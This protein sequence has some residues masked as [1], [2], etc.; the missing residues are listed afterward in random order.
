M[1]TN[2]NKLAT[3]LGALLLVLSVSAGCD[4]P[5]DPRTWAKQLDSLRTQKEALDNL[6]RME[7]EKARLALPELT[8]LFESS[9][10]P[11]HLRAIARLKDPSTVDL[12]IKELDFTS[13]DFENATIAVGFLGDM[14]V[15]SAVAAL[16]KAVGRTLP[17][18]SR[19][20]TVRLA[21]IR[22]LATIG[23]PAATEPLIR[24]LTG[25]ADE[26]D[27]L[28][29]KKAAL[30][31]AEL[32][33]ASAIPGLLQGLFMTGRGANVFQEC[34][35][36]LVRIG[37]PAIDPLIAL[38]QRKNAEVEAMAKKQEFSDNAIIPYKAAYVLGDLRAKKAV[39][40]LLEQLKQPQKGGELS[41]VLIALGQIGV[42]EGVD[43]LI[44]TL[45]NDKIE[46]GVRAAASNGLSMSGDKR[47]VP[48]LLEIAK[49]GYVVVGGQKAS[50]LRASAAVDLAR[51]A[52]KDYYAA[53]NAI[54]ESEKDAEGIFAEVL[55]RMELA[56]T[57]DKDI[58]CYAKNLDDE[59]PARAEKAAFA[60]GFSGDPKKGIPLLLGALKP[61]ASL[62][63]ERFLVHQAI[64]YALGQ[65]ADK[66]CTECVEKLNG[67]IEKD[68]K[69]ALRIPGAG[70]LLGETRV[71]LA[72]IAAR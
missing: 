19:A 28:L 11:E 67:Q 29:N 40:A 44:A 31:L 70:D 50:D 72:R 3:L 24:A 38:L 16:G 34:R 65:L 7:P 26:Q 13:D 14:K 63:H 27:F 25:S 37:E 54:A 6:A 64:L 47:A 23:D 4:D 18:K 8:K 68:E 51:I 2:Q 69:S 41:S 57:C 35:L 32:A 5:N 53:F 33:D 62:K 61:I 1:R 12:F 15:K 45:K 46:P 42:P 58:S 21:A 17:I 36:A 39:P 49:S 71:V 66:S 22:A 10:K 9:D 52:G 30:A 59:S 56:N 60:I 20:N 43:A 55:E 48:V